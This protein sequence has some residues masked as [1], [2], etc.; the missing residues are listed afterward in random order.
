MKL[1]LDTHTFFWLASGNSQL[2]ER[3]KGLLSDSSNQ[4]YLSVLSVWELSI[5]SGLGKLKLLVSL[6]EFTERAIQGYGLVMISVS[7]DDCVYYENLGF[8]DKTHRDPF[9]RMIICQSKRRD[10]T[11]L[12]KDTVF[13]E[14]MVKRIW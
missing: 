12:G 6:E 10:L 14:Y 11:I 13:D 2:S 3:A 9:D 5:K 4:L 7:Q 1:L 8:P